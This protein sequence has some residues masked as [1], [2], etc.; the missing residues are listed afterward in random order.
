MS[1]PEFR[2]NLCIIYHGFLT[3]ESS[4]STETNF[5]F[6]WKFRKSFKSSVSKGLIDIF[7]EEKLD[8]SLIENIIGS[9]IRRLVNYSRTSMART[10]MAR[11]PRDAIFN[12]FLSP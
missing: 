3:G 5:G 4:N 1:L 10:L 6:Q 7:A 11:L 2:R 8:Y 9:V 12:S